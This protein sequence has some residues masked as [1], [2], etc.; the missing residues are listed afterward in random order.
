MLLPYRIPP[1][2]DNKEGKRFQMQ[3]SMIIDIVDMTT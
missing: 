1:N 2:N 3:T